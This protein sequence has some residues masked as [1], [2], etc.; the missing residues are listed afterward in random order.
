[1]VER[2]QFEDFIERRI[3]L[4]LPYAGPA[5]AGSLLT[6]ALNL[7][8]APALQVAL[9]D[10][11]DMATGHAPKRATVASGNLLSR[12]KRVLNRQAA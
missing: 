12:L 4:H 10:L 3:D 5:L 9:Q 8:A 2:S 7:T 1:V 6:G 11:A